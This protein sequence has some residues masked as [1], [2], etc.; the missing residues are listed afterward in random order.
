MLASGYVRTNQ[1]PILR[2]IFRLLFEVQIN[3]E[4][5]VKTLKLSSCLKCD[6][7]YNVDWQI[8]RVLALQRR[9]TVATRCHIIS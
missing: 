6:S 1:L 3:M 4:T 8:W 7:P 2:P 9:S 5:E